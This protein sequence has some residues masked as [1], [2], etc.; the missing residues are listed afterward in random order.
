MLFDTTVE[1]LGDLACIE[2]LNGG[3]IQR[4]FRRDPAAPQQLV[5][6]PLL[7]LGRAGRLG[8]VSDWFTVGDAPPAPPPPPPAA[9]PKLRGIGPGEVRLIDGGEHIEIVYGHTGAMA[10]ASRSHQ[11]RPLA[12]LVPA[13]AAATAHPL[14]AMAHWLL[15]VD[16]GRHGPGR[17]MMPVPVPGGPLVVWACGLRALRQ[18][19][20]AGTV[21]RGATWAVADGL[22]GTTLGFGVSRDEALA[23]WRAAVLAEPPWPVAEPP[24]EPPPELPEGAILVRGPTSDVAPPEPLPQHVPAAIVP[25]APPP[26]TPPPFGSWTTLLGAYGATSFAACKRKRDGFTLI[27]QAAVLN[28]DLTELAGTLDR[29]DAEHEALVDEA[30][31]KHPGPPRRWP[32]RTTSYTVQPDG[33]LAWVGSAEQPAWHAGELDGDLVAARVVR[34]LRVDGTQPPTA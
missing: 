29:L 19:L 32:V 16:H 17:V 25:L 7:E 6:W 15:G 5:P 4:L 33:R 22:T 3:S 24:A 27:G 26:A 18:A 28:I 31:A 34:Q 20:F 2:S 12:G 30:Y 1:L 23:N 21:P 8:I 10:E 11:P 14:E 9:A 13:L